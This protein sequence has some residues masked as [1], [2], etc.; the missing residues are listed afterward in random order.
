MI[1]RRQFRHFQDVFEKLINFKTEVPPDWPK[2]AWL[3]KEGYEKGDEDTFFFCESYLY[4]L[5]G[6]DDARTLLFII[7]RLEE[8]LK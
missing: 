7:R 3:G 6:K 4:N 8:S 5:I 1:T 2:K